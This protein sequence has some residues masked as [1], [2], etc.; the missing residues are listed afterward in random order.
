MLPKNVNLSIVIPTYNRANFLDYSLSVHVPVFQKYNIP[1]FIS[2][3]AS[4]D[5]TSD[6]IKKWK[7]KYPL[8]ES[9]SN[10]KTVSAD[11]NIEAALGLS[12]SK[13]TWLLGD[14]YLLPLELVDHVLKV[15]D[16]QNN[17]DMIICNLSSKLSNPPEQYTDHN[18]LLADIGALMT[19]LSCLI[20]HE[21]VIKDGCF[22]R[23]RGTSFLQLGG[24]LEYINDKAF[25]IAWLGDQSVLGLDSFNGLSKKNWSHGKDVLEIG[26][27]RWVEFVFSLP[28]SYSLDSK[29]TCIKNF[30]SLSNLFTLSGLALMR[31][32]GNLTV[33]SYKAHSLEIGFVTKYPKAVVMFFSIFPKALLKVFCVSITT[34]LKKDKVDTWCS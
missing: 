14:A 4:N 11:E 7:E 9:K 10:L 22:D 3:N 2:D 28:T 34:I 8:I 6:V 16:K 31:M 30:G 29:L 33:E 1:V 18:K 27:K 17:H 26:A 24:A 21:R 19:C 5:Q 20:Y 13:Y 23:Y 15:I 25:S 32:R 12:K